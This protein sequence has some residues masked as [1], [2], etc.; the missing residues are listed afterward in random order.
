MSEAQV[1][2]PVPAG[3]A[4]GASAT[5]T[6]GPRRGSV[7]FIFVT[8]ALDTLGIGLIIPVAPRLV[9]SFVEGDLSSTSSKL[10]WLFVLYSLM[11]FFFAPVLGGL[12]DRFG[13]RP[14]I[15]GSLLGAAC[16]YLASALAPELWW[17]Y[18]GRTVAG[19]TG[20][21]FSCA[22]SYV[23]DVTPPEKRAQSFG[24]IGAAF[25]LGFILGPALGGLLGQYGLRVP[26]FAAAALNLLNL[27]YGLFVLP[28]SLPVE[29]RRPFSFARANAFGAFFVLARNPLVRGLTA[30]MSCSFLSQF[31]LQSV[32]ALHSQARFGWTIRQVGLSLMAVGLSSAIVQGA[33]VRR[34]VGS[35]GERKALL[36]GVTASALGFL[37]FGLADRGWLM[38][39]FILPF[40]FG[41]VAGPATQAMITR[42]VPP[43]EQGEVQG[44]IS[45][46]QGVAAIIGPFI[47]LGLLGAYGTPGAEPYIP[48]APYFAAAILSFLG[49]LF[50][51]RLFAR[52]PRQ[53]KLST[54]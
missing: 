52:E 20:A 12:S 16:S 43:T 54:G 6:A 2:A 39:V 45:G 17:L 4:V 14:V 46:L 32:W 33:L 9:A 13:R 47:G 26:Y 1:D 22:G 15:F 38:Y 31:I 23:A 36:A 28:E 24:L 34:V 44:S 48:G 42:E 30:T 7:A 8:V 3:G 10:R 51:L 11:Q 25:G 21:S 53:A 35:L 41:G 29:K 5:G 27:L 50:A 40:A 18:V 19:I 49:L 37:A